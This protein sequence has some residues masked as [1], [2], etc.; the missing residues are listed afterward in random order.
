MENYIVFADD[1]GKHPSSCQHLFRHIN[2][3]ILWVNTVMRM[4]K[5]TLRDV[6]RIYQKIFSSAKLTSSPKYENVHVKRIFMIP[7]FTRFFRK[8]N[9][10]L[11]F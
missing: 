9:T 4:P 6:K 11:L 8:I 3:P 2:A 1:W 10:L 5:F 7:I